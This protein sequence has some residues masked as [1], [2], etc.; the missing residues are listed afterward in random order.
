MPGRPDRARSVAAA[1]AL[2]LGLL[3]PAAAGQFETATL[4]APDG[5]LN[6]LFGTSVF[7]SGDLI[8]VGAHLDDDA[9]QNSG[10]AY[11]Y[12]RDQAGS[13]RW[14]FRMKLTASDGAA[15]DR[16]GFSVGLSGD[17]ALVGAYL[18]DDA[19]LNSGSAYVFARDAGGVDQWGMVRKIKASDGEE[20]DLFGRAVAINGAYAIAGA[21]QDDDRGSNSGSAYIFERDKGGMNMWGEA[22]KISAPDGVPGDRFGIAVAM[23][24]GVAAVGAADIN[25]N[26]LG[27]VCVFARDESMGGWIF[28]DKLVAPDAVP[29]D[30]FG[31]AVSISGSVIVA[32]SPGDGDLGASSGSAYVFA[33][34]M[35]DLGDWRLVT[36]LN[37]SDGGANDRFGIAVAVSGDMIVVGANSLDAGGADVGSAYLFQRNQGGEVHWGQV[38]RLNASD[39]ASGDGYAKAVSI[40]NA[41]VVVGAHGHDQPVN[42]AGAAYV[43]DP[44]V[45]ACPADSDGSGAVDVSDLLD[46]LAAWGPCPSCPQDNDGNDVVDVD[47]LLILLAAWGAC[48]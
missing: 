8:I 36:K 44:T 43:H 48:P 45:V 32:G 3:A 46:L 1:L 6:D 35:G 26:R 34:L 18:D 40:S 41:I 38:G 31:V 7:I 10:S 4:L 16:F 19:E 17:T 15:E 39:H 47:D 37:A 27:A 28:R 33:P 42:S 9:G 13:G 21:I 12:M 11:V 25:A 29:G 20:A 2:A 24:N 30:G 5:A 14:S 22:D 23:G